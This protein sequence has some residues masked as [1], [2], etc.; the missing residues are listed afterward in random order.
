MTQDEP[1]SEE[2]GTFTMPE[3]AEDDATIYLV[4]E[5]EEAET[6]AADSTDDV[7]TVGSE[8]AV[9]PAVFSVEEPITE[10]RTTEV[11]FLSQCSSLFSPSM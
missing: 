2:H 3:I 4:E 5:T 6:V 8:F 9:S 7:I 1:M 10:G 11:R